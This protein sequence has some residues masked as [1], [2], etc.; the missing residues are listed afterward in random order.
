MADLFQNFGSPIFNFNY[1]KNMWM[2]LHDYGELVLLK[3]LQKGIIVGGGIFLFYN[4]QIIYKYGACKKEYLQFRPYNALIWE[5][6]LMGL[7]RK[8]EH[9]NLGAVAVGEE[10]LIG[11][12]KSWGANM[13]R[14]LFYYFPVEGN[15]PKIENYFNSFSLAKTIW[16]HL[17][18]TLVNNLGPK[19]YEWIC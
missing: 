11:F 12:K 15:S 17:P 5:A 4:D 3:I 14:S 10:G 6:I 8:M 7:E 1:L 18:R 9:L 19:T 13:H 2:S 16:R